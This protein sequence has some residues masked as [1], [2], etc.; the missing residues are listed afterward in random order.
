MGNEISQ[1]SEDIYPP[2][3]VLTLDAFSMPHAAKLASQQASM[4]PESEAA[5]DGDPGTTPRGVQVTEEDYWCAAVLVDG[6]EVPGGRIYAYPSSPITIETESWSSRLQLHFFPSPTDIRP[7]SS[8]TAP[9][10]KLVRFGAP[11]YTSL[12]LGL[13]GEES[14]RGPLEEDLSDAL[15]WAHVPDAPKVKIT[16]FRPAGNELLQGTSMTSSRAAKFEPDIRRIF[17][18]YDGG[19][20][21]CLEPS[22]QSHA[23]K[24]SQVEGLIRC[25]DETNELIRGFHEAVM[26]RPMRDKLTLDLER[27]RRTLQAAEERRTAERARH[28]DVIATLVKELSDVRA[29]NNLA[30]E[31]LEA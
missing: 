23:S 20:P 28:G 21:L 18:D 11:L 15:T 19:G 16:L 24:Q 12:W 5:V 10:S 4:E 2:R 17:D 26:M 30:K 3:M 27:A 8:V 9:L 6:V 7:R 31:V 25:L 22:P 13:R 29:R 1:E 14:S